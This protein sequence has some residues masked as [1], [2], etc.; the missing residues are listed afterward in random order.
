M[1][2][3]K[4]IAMRTAKGCAKIVTKDDVVKAAAAMTIAMGMSADDAE[5]ARTAFADMTD[6]MGPKCA[7]VQLNPFRGFI[8]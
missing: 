6:D 8:A 3:A 5:A 7:I 2:K 4:I 1:K